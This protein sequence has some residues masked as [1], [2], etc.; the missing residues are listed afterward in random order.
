M[1]LTRFAFLALCSAVICAAPFAKAADAGFTTSFQ[2]LDKQIWTISDGWTNGDWQACEWRADALSF[3]QGNLL[4]T[5][6]DKGGKL[7]PYSCPEIQTNAKHGY[8]LYEARLRTAAG[9]GLNTAFFTYIGPP[10]GVP[11]HDEIDF[12]FLGKDPRTVQVNYWVN[13]KSRD[14]KIIPLGFDASKEFH[15]Y[16]I[17]WAPQKIR[18]Y[19]DGQIVHTTPDDAVLP[20]NPGK[21]FFSLWVGSKINENW[22]GPFHYTAPITAEIA[23]AA[24]TPMNEPC[25]FPQSPT[26]KQKR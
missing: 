7:R 8:G 19:V 6:S 21:L 15:D 12:E 10:F 5:L 3:D 23:R 13:G 18:W 2:T 24:F 17:E 16:A 1:H 22:L 4:L 14:G 25:P 20:R 26:C 11:Q 9:S